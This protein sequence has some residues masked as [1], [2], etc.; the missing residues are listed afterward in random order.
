MNERGIEDIINTLFEMIQEARSVP[1]SSEKCIIEREKALDLLDE[2]LNQLPGE[3]KQART[4]VESRGEVINNAKREAENILK[5]AQSQARQMVSESEIT[6]Q[7]Q[8]SAQEML[9][10]AQTESEATVQRAQARI[11]ELKK[12]T[13]DF[14]DSALRTTEESISEAL[15]EIRDTRKKFNAVVGAQARPENPAIIEDV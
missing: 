13:T 12:V 5:Q 11:R 2:I 8:A 14:V 15:G 7:A 10:Q 4:I 3:L 6:Q 9:R 1:L